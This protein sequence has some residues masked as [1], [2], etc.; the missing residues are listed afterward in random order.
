[1]DLIISKNFKT[2]TRGI[3]LSGP[4]A[5]QAFEFHKQNKSQT[6]KLPYT[7]HMELLF[8]STNK[9]HKALILVPAVCRATCIPSL[10]FADEEKTRQ[11]L[12]NLP[13]VSLRTFLSHAPHSLIKLNYLEFS[14]PIRFFC[15]AT[16]LHK[17]LFASASFF[18]PTG[19]FLQNS[20]GRPLRKS[21][22]TSSPSS[23]LLPF[24][25]NSTFHF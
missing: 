2:L 10:Y 16:I 4:Q 5:Y 15:V 8:T 7:C 1:M 17:C 21:S 19:L 20:I 22:L 14:K 23:S 6:G 11:S 18:F 9:E 24:L 25:H 13:E 12:H 3:H